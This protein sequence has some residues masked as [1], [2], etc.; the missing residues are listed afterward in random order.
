MGQKIREG[1]SVNLNRTVVHDH[2]ADIDGGN[3]LGNV[4]VGSTA[5]LG[6]S[7]VD[8]GNRASNT[9]NRDT[10]INL[11]GDD[12]YTSYA[13]QILR[14]GSAGGANGPTT[15]T[16]RGTGLLSIVASEA[17]AIAF[18]TSGTEAVRILANNYVGLGTLTPQTR[19]HVHEANAN[20]LVRITMA[21]AG[22]HAGVLSG[23]TNGVFAGWIDSIACYNVANDIPVG[24]N[25]KDWFRIGSTGTQAGTR[26]GQAPY[27]F[28]DDVDTAKW[29]ADNGD[30][31]LTFFS[32]NADTS[33]F[34]GAPG[35]ASYDSRTYRPK[36]R[37]N[38]TGKIQA[39][40]LECNASAFGGSFPPN[41]TTALFNNIS[42][43]WLKGHGYSGGGGTSGTDCFNVNLYFRNG[44]GDY[45]IFTITPAGQD[46]K[47]VV[48]VI[49]T[50][51]SIHIS[52]VV[53]F[54]ANTGTIRIGTL[55]DNGTGI[56]ADYYI[57]A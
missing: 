11:H 52:A 30:Y 45:T 16:H 41:S 24:T 53:Q 32:D 8:I 37:F 29:L 21:G 26:L 50:I 25:S 7:S 43:N 18:S 42:G 55:Q 15:I 27:V 31:A 6:T 40:S 38:K 19:L 17:A 5:A 14:Q 54:T 28:F 33:T 35:N 10:Y 51:V 13:L 47:P 34:F 22:D 46:L 12:V 57:R 44:T 49:G 48:T 1:E 36:V 4:N 23:K 2:S 39:T 20:A 56:D 3:N 9:G